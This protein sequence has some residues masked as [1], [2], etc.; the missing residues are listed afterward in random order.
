[1][2]DVMKPSPG[3]IRLTHG[4]GG[5]S[6]HNNTTIN[7]DDTQIRRGFPTVQ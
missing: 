3:Q 2:Y 1:M 5:G 4:P 7:I 6:S